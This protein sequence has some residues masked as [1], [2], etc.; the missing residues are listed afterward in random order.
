MLKIY[1]F[2]KSSFFV[3]FIFCL[4]FV[5]KMSSQWD[6][7]IQSRLITG[8]N[9]KLNKKW[10]FDFEYRYNLKENLKEFKSSVFQLETCYKLNKKWSANSGVRFDTNYNSDYLML[11][12]K[13]GYSQKI[14]KKLKLKSFVRYQYKNIYN[15]FFFLNNDYKKITRQ[16]NEIKYSLSN[17]QVSF[18]G[19]M[20]LFLNTDTENG[21][22]VFNQIRYSLSLGYDLKKY[23]NIKLRTFWDSHYGYD[24][25]DRTVYSFKYVYTL[26]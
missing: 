1:D 15:D 7:D 24:N 5:S 19:G 6:R 21:F 9:Y 11:F 25:D 20:E 23:G 3:T 16:K 13:L 17:T 26:D 18:K 12:V 14:I 10:K 2:M 22:F 8:I 4:V